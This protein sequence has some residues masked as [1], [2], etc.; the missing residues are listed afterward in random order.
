MIELSIVM[1][2]LNEAETLAVCVRKAVAVIAEMKIE[3]EV[4]V[5]DNGSTD[6]SVELAESLGARV[7]RARQLMHG[8]TSSV[9]HDGTGVFAG[10]PDGLTATRYHSLVI[11]D[12]P[13][14][15]VTNAWLEEASQRV[16]MGV[17]HRDTRFTVCSL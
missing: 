16:V 3:G 7:V 13:D 15:L 11:E 10:L 2:C 12:L 8:K 17:R 9:S 14:C 6:G 5:A 4:I 1:P